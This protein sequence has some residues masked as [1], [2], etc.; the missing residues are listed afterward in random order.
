MAAAIAS[1][2]RRARPSVMYPIWLTIWKERICLML[3]R[4]AASAK[5]LALT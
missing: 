5:N 4:V 2:V 3:K 1:W